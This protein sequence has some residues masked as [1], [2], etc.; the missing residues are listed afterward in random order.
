MNL[1]PSHRIPKGQGKTLATWLKTLQPNR[2]SWICKSTKPVSQI[3]LYQFLSTG[4]FKPTCRNFIYSRFMFCQKH[5]GCMIIP[6]DQLLPSQHNR[7]GKIDL[8]QLLFDWARTFLR[9]SSDK[10]SSS[11]FNPSIDEV[12]AIIFYSS[13]KNNCENHKKREWKIK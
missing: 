5:Q 1:F 4:K 13:L 7:P 8:Q 3:G 2:N 6:S 9:I 10:I 12:W 11:Y